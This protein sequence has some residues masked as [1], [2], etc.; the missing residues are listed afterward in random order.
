MACCLDT[1]IIVFCLRGKSA[2]V[3]QRLRTTP[4]SGGRVPMQVRAELL[5]GAARSAWPVPN[6][7]KVESFLKPEAE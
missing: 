6:T 7:A 2:K 4:A 1:N 5:V 3:M